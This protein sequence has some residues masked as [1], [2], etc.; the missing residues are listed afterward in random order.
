[1]GWRMNCVPAQSLAPLEQANT[2]GDAHAAVIEFW[3]VAST[4]KRAKIRSSPPG[5]APKALALGAAL[6][7]LAFG[8]TF[9]L[10]NR[11][12]PAKRT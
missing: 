9:G 10:R 11:R 6:A 2:P 5:S 12:G 1:S 3:F 4:P 8:A 7:A